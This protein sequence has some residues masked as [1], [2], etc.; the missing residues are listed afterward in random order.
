MSASRNARKRPKASGPDT[1]PPVDNTA[2]PSVITNEQHHKA[3]RTPDDGS[4][5]DWARRVGR[6]LDGATHVARRG[7]V[8]LWALVGLCGAALAL[9]AV[10]VRF[11]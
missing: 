3:A 4:V 2:A 1:T 11:G 5:P 10:L 7:R 6:Q 9:V 8:L